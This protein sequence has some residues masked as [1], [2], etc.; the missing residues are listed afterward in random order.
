M[1]AVSKRMKGLRITLLF[2]MFCLQHWFCFAQDDML[3]LLNQQDTV[4]GKEFVNPA[5]KTSRIINLQT[6]EVLKKKLLDVKISHRFSAIGTSSNVSSSVHNLWGFDESSDIRISFDYGI[7]TNWNVGFAR[8]KYLE[9]WELN[10]KY[11][12]ASQRR[13]NSTPL[14]ATVFCVGT[15][16]SKQNWSYTFDNPS[17]Q[18]E[19][20]RHFS[21]ASQLILSRKMSDRLSLEVSP[22]F[23]HRNFVNATDNNNS[24]AIGAGGRVRI[25]K[26][27][28]FVAD[29]VY[30][31]GKYRVIG[32]KNGVYN[33]LG[34]G[35]E[36]ETGG[37]VFS[38]MFSNAPS[39]TETQ[40]ITDT[41][42]TWTTGGTR[43]CF[44]ISRIFDFSKKKPEAKL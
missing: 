29:Y 23:V 4:T 11:K 16:S 1:P 12:F 31:L 42:D 35:L 17:E 24:F 3:K 37:H 8:S 7:L 6:A 36:F 43:L 13:D 10:S 44:T 33:P 28:S 21:F 19:F 41:R 26:R 20:K 14:T 2:L 5:F 30:N 22:I 15:Y 25:T 18:E 27:M 38:L 39:I 34:L 40:F 32:N 9:N